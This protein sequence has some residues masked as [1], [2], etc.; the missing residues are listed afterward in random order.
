[1]EDHI[2]KVQKELR[3]DFNDEIQSTLEAMRRLAEIRGDVTQSPIAQITVSAGGVGVWIAAMCAG[4]CFV[5]VVVLA[6]LYVDH[7]RKI[8]DLSHYLNAIYMQAPHLKP[9][10][11]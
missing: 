2:G 6:L 3:K 7:S 10:E 8:D 9:E 1:M 11:K 4:I 5:V